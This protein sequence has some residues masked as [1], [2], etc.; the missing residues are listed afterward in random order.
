M[1]LLI[2]RR[3]EISIGTQSW[4]NFEGEECNLPLYPFLFVVPPALVDQVVLE[5]KCFLKSGAFDIIKYVA[6]YKTHKDVWAQIEK[7]SFTEAHM[8]IYIAS[9]TVSF[10]HF[11][12]LR[13]HI[14]IR[15]GI[16]VRL[17]FR[18]RRGHDHAQ[19]GAVLRQG[20]QTGGEHHLWAPVPRGCNRRSSRFPQHKQTTYG[21]ARAE[22]Q[23]R[24]T[25]G[26]DRDARP[27][28]AHGA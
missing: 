1:A 14:N 11:H 28:E 10:T 7:Q 25:G 6:G 3:A 8:R 19:F 13:N 5:C 16:A 18:A 22:R 12:K 15:P 21:G 24:R 27:N 20:W 26:D 2:A 23:D 9:T 17:Q 4:T